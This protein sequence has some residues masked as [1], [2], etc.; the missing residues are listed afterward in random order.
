MTRRL[1]QFKM[2][3]VL[4]MTEHLDDFDELIVGLQTLGEPVDE[5]RQ[6]VLL[7]SS[8]PSEYDIDSA[9]VENAKDV[10]LIEVKEKLLKEY[11]RLEKKDTTIEKAFRANEN[12]GRIKGGRGH[13]RKGI[14]LMK[15]GRGYK[16]KCFGRG[17]VVHIKRDCPVQKR[18]SGNDAVFAVSEK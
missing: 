1:H 3:S 18:D 4:T 9:I 14:S 8:L 11:E 16:G 13:G 12:A 7:K 5:A 10:S 6:L 15:N 17:Q 2:E